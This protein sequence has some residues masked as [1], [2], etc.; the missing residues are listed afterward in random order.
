M[1]GWRIEYCAA[2]DSYTAAPTAFNEFF[3]QRRRWMPSTIANIFDLLQDYKHVC[4]SNPDISIFYIMYQSMIMVGTVLGPGT[5]FL[6]LVGA[7]QA[8]FKWAFWDAFLFQLF[9][10]IGFMMFCQY[11]KKDV[12]LIVAQVLT[13]FYVLVMM[14]VLVGIL[15]QMSEDGLLSPSA[16]GIWLVGGSF[17]LSAIMHPQGNHTLFKL[18]HCFRNVIQCRSA[19]LYFLYQRNLIL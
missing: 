9:P 3:N 16:L 18:E 1:Q 13:M 12:Q 7:L 11:S 14:A 19:E 6:M 2:S 5:I 4:E 10:I 15:L 17:V 8:A